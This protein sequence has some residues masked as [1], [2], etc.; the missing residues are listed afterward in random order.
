[1]L[2]DRVVVVTGGAGLIGQEFVRVIV[3]N[4]GIAIIADIEKEQALIVR[5]KLSQQLDSQNINVVELDITLFP[6]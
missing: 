6:P 4:G 1:M 2:T 5:K 3:E